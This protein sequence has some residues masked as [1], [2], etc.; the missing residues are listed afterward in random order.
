MGSLMFFCNQFLLEVGA[1]SLS[2]PN[3]ILSHE[4]KNLR[5]V[6][7]F[8]SAVKQDEPGRRHKTVGSIC[9]DR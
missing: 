6:S 7:S 8:T 4:V 9:A 2:S 5:A 1:I 3:Q